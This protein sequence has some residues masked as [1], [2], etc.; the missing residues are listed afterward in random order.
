M[1]IDSRAASNRILSQIN[2]PDTRHP[3]VLIV[4]LR[5]LSV[6]PIKSVTING[7]EWT[8]FDVQ[9]K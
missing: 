6:K 1:N 4:R 8:D 2:M 9:K 5:H 7:R 3:D